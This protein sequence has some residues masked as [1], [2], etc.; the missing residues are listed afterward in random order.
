MATAPETT[1]WPECPACGEAAWSVGNDWQKGWAIGHA[2]QALGDCRVSREVG[3]AFA[4]E[5]AER[6]KRAQTVTAPL[7]ATRD[8]VEAVLRT[9]RMDDEAPV[10][11]LTDFDVHHV[12]HMLFASG[13]LRDPDTLADDEAL[14]ERVAEAFDEWLFRM[15][16]VTSSCDH[17]VEARGILA[18]ALTEDPS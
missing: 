5:W 16:G 8:A 10:R 2:N 18:A 3:E 9:C 14:V 13:V 7:L 6:D 15:H 4:A 17:K 1:K 11:L 12:S